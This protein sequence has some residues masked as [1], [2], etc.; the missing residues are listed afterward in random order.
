M[1]ER[2]KLFLSVA[3]AGLLLILLAVTVWYNSP[4]QATKRACQEAVKERIRSPGAA[5]F[6]PAEYER[7]MLSKPQAEVRGWVDAANAYGTPIRNY[8]LCMIESQQSIEVH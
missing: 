8:Y 1:G 4:R 6:D 2:L 5:V 3:G 7:T